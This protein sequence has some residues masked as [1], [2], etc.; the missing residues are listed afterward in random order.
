MAQPPVQHGRQTLGRHPKEIRVSISYSLR[1]TAKRI[2]YRMPFLN[3]LSRPRYSYNL[4]PAQLALLVDAIDR[5]SHLSGAILEV[6]V[7]RGL[8]TIFLKTHMAEL[9]D[10][11]QYICVDTF[12]GFTDEDVDF[13]RQSRGKTG[14]GFKSFAYNDVEVFRRNMEHSGFT[15]IKIIQKDCGFLSVDDIGPVSVAILDVDLY[16]PTKR[17]IGTIYDAM[18]PGG[19][20]MVDDVKFGMA[21]DGAASA[22]F[23]F[24]KCRGI[25]PNVFADKAGM[26]VRD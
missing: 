19:V 12:S 26:L 5:T 2:A 14:D 22:Y 18:Q 7:A 1:E 8:S 23:E 16:L 20:L 4:S 11:R 15:D 10:C 9:G 6:G 3:W 13:E 17:A 24:C 25:K 21:Y